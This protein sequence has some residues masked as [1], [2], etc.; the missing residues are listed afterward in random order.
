MTT[1]FLLCA[2]ITITSALVSLGFSIA[3][4]RSAE[5][6]SR[7]NAL[8]AT[9]RSTA[10]AAICLVPLFSSSYEWLVAVASCMILVQAIDAG[11]G[12]ARKD[13]MK[14]FGPAATSL[15]N[16]LALIWL[17]SRH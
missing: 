9:A 17:I 8:Y 5:G 6:E 1:P 15:A 2:A 13:K 12:V 14:T 3:A 7:I 16:L 11:I 10:L 4:V